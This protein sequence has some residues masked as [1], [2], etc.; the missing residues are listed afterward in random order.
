MTIAA[1]FYNTAIDV[2][3]AVAVPEKNLS[4]FPITACLAISYRLRALVRRCGV[5]RGAL[6][7]CAHAYSRGQ[8]VAPLVAEPNPIR[9]EANYLVVRGRLLPE[10][11]RAWILDVYKTVR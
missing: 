5:R 10:S 9:A 4:G 1:D 8:F 11:V 7:A 3:H 2:V 6:Y